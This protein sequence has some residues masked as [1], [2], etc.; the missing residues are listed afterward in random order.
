MSRSLIK[1]T[2]WVYAQKFCTAFITL[3]STPII[4]KNLGVEDYGIYT[5]TFG[6]VAVFNFM[7]WSLTAATQRFIA[8]NIARNKNKELIRVFNNSLFI[9]LIYAV[10]LLLAI[11]TVGIFF[12]DSIL[13][14]PAEKVNTTKYVISFVSLITF[15]KI[16]IIPYEGLLKAYENFKIIS[17][18]GIVDSIFKLTAALLLFFAPFDKLVFFSVLMLISNVIIFLSYLIL[19]SKQYPIIIL[20]FSFLSRKTMSELFSFISWNILGAIAILARNQG[21]GV[22]LNIFFG[23]VANAAYGIALQVQAALGVFSQGVITSFTPRIL[24]SA[25]NDE[26]Q[27]ALSYSYNT[28]KYGIL[29]IALVGFP[30]YFNLEFLLDWWLK[31]IPENTMIYT[32]LIMIF[33]LCTGFSVGL[34]S[35]FHGINRVKTYNL[36]VSLTIMLNIPISFLLFKLNY[37]SYS[38]FV[39]SIVLEVISFFVRLFLVK[40]Y[41]IFSI[42]KY[43]INFTKQVIVPLGFTYALS[44]NITVYIFNDYL[45]I[46]K[47]F[48]IVNSLII[49]LI[50][51]LVAYM[52]SLNSNEKYAI[53]KI[54]SEKILKFNKNRNV[55]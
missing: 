3:A 46:Y 52:L 1:N 14:I 19:V 18:L 28:A 49:V 39:V 50:F 2:I 5:L 22:I 30:V 25:G 48:F 45:T 51:I 43:L 13:S 4:L 55:T 34:Q 32:K 12:T 6:L 38:I 37:P 53:K 24:K 15:F 11:L 27:K 35:F 20:K 40:R 21:V 23:V 16:I 8:V 10:L 17:I 7:S 54:L 44:S 33:I 9:H 36:L 47:Y 29:I 26:P 42:T 41:T 31:V